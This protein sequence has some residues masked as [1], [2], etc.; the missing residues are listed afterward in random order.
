[1]LFIWMNSWGMQGYSPA[2]IYFIL[3]FGGTVLTAS[4]SYHLIEKPLL[5]LKP[6]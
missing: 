1:V 5:K 4:I 3:G 2:L 6:H